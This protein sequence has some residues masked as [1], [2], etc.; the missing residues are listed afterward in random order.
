M[1]AVADPIFGT[2]KLELL[3]G[4]LRNQQ[5]KGNIQ[6]GP[7]TKKMKISNSK[8]MTTQHQCAGKKYWFILY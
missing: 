3:W 1:L 7:K 5:Q 4:T 6:H 8:N 2:R